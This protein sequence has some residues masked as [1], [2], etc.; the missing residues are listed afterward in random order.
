M[1]PYKIQIVQTWHYRDKDRRIEVIVDL[2]VSWNQIPIFVITCGMEMRSILISRGWLT[3]TNVE[4]R[5]QKDTHK[6]FHPAKW[7]IW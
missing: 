6:I 1:I 5:V 2:L 3:N 4:Y 7:S